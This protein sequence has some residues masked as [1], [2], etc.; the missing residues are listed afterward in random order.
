[1]MMLAVSGVAKVI[2]D[3]KSTTRGILL[4]VVLPQ[5]VVVG[6]ERA[7]SRSIDEGEP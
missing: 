4:V 6:R 7:G 5:R 2:T 3:G 1:M